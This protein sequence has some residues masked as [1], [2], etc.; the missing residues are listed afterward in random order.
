MLSTTESGL[1]FLSPIHTHTHTHTH[2]LSYRISAHCTFFP[3]IQHPYTV[4]KAIRSYLGFSILPKDTSE[5]RLEVQ[6]GI[7]RFVDD[8]LYPLS[9]SHPWINLITTSVFF[10]QKMNHYPCIQ[11]RETNSIFFNFK[12]SL[13]FFPDISINSRPWYMRSKCNNLVIVWAGR[14]PEIQCYWVRP[15]LS[16]Q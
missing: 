14:N 5:C 8:T 2:T 3:I 11:L 16:F 12:Y 9:H 1:E 6:M 15:L 7:K 13:K 4:S 10:S